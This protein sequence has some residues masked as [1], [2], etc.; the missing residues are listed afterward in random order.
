MFEIP[1]A[2]TMINS[3]TVNRLKT[4]I[5]RVKRLLPDK[6]HHLPEPRGTKQ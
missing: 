3:L 1:L 5:I 4:P 2:A 6:P